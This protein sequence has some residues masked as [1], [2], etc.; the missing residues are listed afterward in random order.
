VL[1]AGQPDHQRD[2]GAVQ[3]GVQ[4][5]HPACL[6][7]QGDREVE[8]ERRLAHAALAAGDCDHP[9]GRRV[10]DTGSTTRSDVDVEPPLSA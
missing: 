1:A 6:A 4:Q 9:L 8:A 7:G 10:P 3:I 2:V 5:A